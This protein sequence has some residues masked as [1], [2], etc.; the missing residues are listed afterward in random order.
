MQKHN[1]NR[2]TEMVKLA[3]R[4]SVSAIFFKLPHGDDPGRRFLLSEEDLTAFTTWVKEFHA[5]TARVMTNLRQIHSLLTSVFHQKDC[6]EG[7]P[8]RTFYKDRRVHSGRVVLLTSS[9][10]YPLEERSF[11]STGV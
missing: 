1:V 8:V 2:W 11:S 3:E 5:L 7:R 4:L 10:G 6:I 9:V